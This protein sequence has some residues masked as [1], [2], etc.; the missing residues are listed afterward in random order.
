NR[1]DV[2]GGGG[3]DWD[4]LWRII[5]GPW[6]GNIPSERQKRRER[7]RKRQEEDQD[8]V[9]Y[10]CTYK[11]DT[12]E[13]V[14]IPN[15][16]TD[17]GKPKSSLRTDKAVSGNNKQKEIYGKGKNNPQKSW[18]KD[19]GPPE[20]G[21]YNVGR[22]HRKTNE[23]TDRRSMKWDKKQRPQKYSRTGIQLHFCRSGEDTCSDGCIAITD[24]DVWNELND[25]LK[26]EEG[27]NTITVH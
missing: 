6:P 21:T 22:P 1:E 15:E 17:D 11:T 16:T 25:M 18:L 26:T 8:D 24:I 5:R 10:Y 23:S 3:V 7:E 19:S 14:C 9:C 12:H 13:L 4:M 2:D 20:K 27:N